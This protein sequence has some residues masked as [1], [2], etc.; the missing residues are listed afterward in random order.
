MANILLQHFK[1]IGHRPHF[2]VLCLFIGLLLS[3]CATPRQ[4]ETSIDPKTYE[5]EES[6]Q[7]RL[8]IA[9]RHALQFRLA[10]VAQPLLQ[11]NITACGQRT[12]YS[13][14]LLL[15]ALDDYPKAQQA[16]VDQ[17]YQLERY[18]QKNEKTANIHPAV[19]LYA[20][21]N[22]PAAQL[23]PGDRIS[24]INSKVAARETLKL[25]K[26]LNSAL[27]SGQPIQLE[28]IRDR[29]K[30]NV[31]LTPVKICDYAVRLSSSN[32]INGFA[33]GSNIII[34]AG[35]MRF[36]KQDN[37]LALII[38]HELAHNTLAH[39][40]QRFGNTALGLL[41]DIA[42]TAAGVPSPLIG[43]SIGASLFSAAYETEA[44]LEGVRMLHKA[45]YSLKDIDLFWRE[46][47]ALHP[48]SINHGP[49]ASHPSTVKRAIRIRQEIQRLSDAS[50]AV[51]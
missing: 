4:F 9:H 12:R 20:L 42:V 13:L 1:A 14:G 15:H 19:V 18:A 49:T 29:A 11:H 17:L 51:E 50:E 16:A 43:A 44:D 27:Q 31:T 2:F 41:A 38:A 36:A 7:F 10:E 46:M 3:A 24:T 40:P 5:A 6:V 33:D 35:L 32:A 21:N 47:A 28:I 37:Q 23:K 30:I 34:T 39:I 22:S 25:H 45:S 26:Q 48:Q 8:A